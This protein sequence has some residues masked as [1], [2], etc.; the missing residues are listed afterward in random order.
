[1][2]AATGNI[3]RALGAAIDLASLQAEFE[4]GG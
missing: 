4:A 1:V 2:V 3:V